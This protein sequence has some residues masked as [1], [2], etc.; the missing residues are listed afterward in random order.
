MFYYEIFIKFQESSEEP[1]D[2]PQNN[3]R[4]IQE[5]KPKADSIPFLDPW[6]N[7]R[8][9]ADIFKAILVFACFIR[10]NK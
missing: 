10:N 1:I 5:N 3:A 6:L 7:S 2:G 8:P 9:L 4:R